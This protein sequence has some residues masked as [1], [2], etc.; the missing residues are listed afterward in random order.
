MPLV[1]LDSFHK[2]NLWIIFLNTERDEQE[3]KTLSHVSILSSPG[4]C[5]ESTTHR[6]GTSPV[7]VQAKSDLSENAG[8]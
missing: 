2:M 6:S 1:L 4:W 7:K 5:Q 3:M 8:V